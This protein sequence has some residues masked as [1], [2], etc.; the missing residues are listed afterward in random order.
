[1]ENGGG[2]GCGK[3]KN[4]EILGRKIRSQ[5]GAAEKFKIFRSVKPKNFKIF[6]LNF[7]P[8][9]GQRNQNFPAPATAE[10]FWNRAQFGG[11]KLKNFCPRAK[12]DKEPKI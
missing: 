5:T 11:K 3:R 4:S 12:R 2:K 10:N 1:M 7:P 8:P 9:N 6:K